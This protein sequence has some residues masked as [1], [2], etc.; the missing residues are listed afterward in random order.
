MKGV[1]VPGFHWHFLSKDGTTGGHVLDVSFK[2]LVARVDT[3][4]DFSMRLPEALGTLDLGADRKEELEKVEMN[5]A[6]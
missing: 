6:E 1:S 5:P 2:G 3:M 4:R